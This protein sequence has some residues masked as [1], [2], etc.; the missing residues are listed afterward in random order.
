MTP[1]RYQQAIYDAAAEPSARTIAIEAVAGSG[2]TATIEGG[3]SQRPPTPSVYFAFNR[4]TVNAA[5]KRLAALA[6]VL[7]TTVHAFGFRTLREH[8]GCKLSVN[9]DK[10][11]Q[12]VRETLA[13]NP[14]LW[15][16]LQY[17]REWDCM[18]DLLKVV[19]WARTALIDPFDCATDKARD[20]GLV[21]P[22]EFGDLLPN[23]LWKGAKIAEDTGELD[24]TDMLWLPWRWRLQ[25][26]QFSTVCV[27][28]LQDLT[29]SQLW[30]VKQAM[31][32]DGVHLVAGDR[33]QSIMGWAF[34]GGHIYDSAVLDTHKMPLSIC[35]RCPTSHLDLARKLVPHIEARPDAPEGTILTDCALPTY[36]PDTMILCRR[37]AP[38]VETA[39][40]YLRRGISAVVRGRDIGSDIAATIK[41][42]SNGG[43]TDLASLDTAL[44]TYLE[45][46]TRILSAQ[47]APLA[48]QLALRDRVDSALAALEG[49]RDTCTDVPSLITKVSALFSDTNGQAI[50]LSTVHRAKGLEAR[51]VYIL[52]PSLLTTDTEEESNVKYVALTRATHTL[53]F[54]TQ[55]V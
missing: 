4:H 26:D 8:G 45:R 10:Y 1:S 27:D 11:L 28:E 49:V 16:T 38:L 17:A 12:I 32:P 52:Q 24:Y 15:R 21:C 36:E 25:V 5:T 50:T 2:K 44:H 7:F 23:I 9:E 35:Y 29:A 14:T 3:L 41:A 55:D 31:D 18:I 22:D 20:A 40:H 39:F 34:A 48:Q 33:N 47:N 53:G 30:L 43:R 13:D 51:H 19:S 6:H 37:T 54:I 42:A 46:R